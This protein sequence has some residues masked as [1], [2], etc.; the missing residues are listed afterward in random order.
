MQFNAVVA[1]NLHARHLYERISFVPLGI[2]PK[3]FRIKDGHYKDACPYNYTLLP[4][5]SRIFRIPRTAAF[6]IAAEDTFPAHRI[7]GAPFC[8]I[9]HKIHKI[10]RIN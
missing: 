5:Y 2:I 8:I 7:S 4:A 3:G 9:I 10:S 6:S 1:S